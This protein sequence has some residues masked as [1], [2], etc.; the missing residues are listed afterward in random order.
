MS[1]LYTGQINVSKIDKERLF[2]GKKGMQMDIIIWVEDNPDED[3]KAVSIQQH[4]KQGEEKIYLGNC[5]LFE[6][7]PMNEQTD[8]NQIDELAF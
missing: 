6:R 5:K 3:W 7:S 1:K 4:T 2:K 8:N